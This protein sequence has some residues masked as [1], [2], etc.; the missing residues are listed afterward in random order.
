MH[1]LG[2]SPYARS[3]TAHEQPLVLG[4]LCGAVSRGD[5]LPL[6]LCIAADVAVACTLAAVARHLLV[7]EEALAREAVAMSSEAVRAVLVV[8]PVPA[9]HAADGAWLPCAVAAA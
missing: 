6:L 1:D 9:S 3:V 2:L 5:A 8:E 7:G 4:A